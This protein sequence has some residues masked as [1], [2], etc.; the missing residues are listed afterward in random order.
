MTSKILFFCCSFCII[1]G[2]L[3]LSDSQLQSPIPPSIKIGVERKVLSPNSKTFSFLWTVENTADTTVSFDEDSLAIV[4]LNHYPVDVD[5][6]P[7]TLSPGD[8]ISI[9][10]PLKNVNFS[11]NNRLSI[12]AKTNEGTV[13]TCVMDIP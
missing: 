6:S 4:T 10:I 12:T 9:W 8:K 5:T 11:E 13:G 2:A 1:I 3:L 7:T